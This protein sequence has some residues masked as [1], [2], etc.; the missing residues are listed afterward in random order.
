MR[1][2]HVYMSQRPLQAVL[3]GPELLQLLTQKVTVQGE[4]MTGFG[5]ESD[6]FLGLLPK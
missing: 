6:S 2:L 3:H 4:D 1:W 5:D